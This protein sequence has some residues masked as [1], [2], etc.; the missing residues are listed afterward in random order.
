MKQLATSR[1]WGEYLNKHKTQGYEAQRCGR[2]LQPTGTVTEICF[3]GYTGYIASRNVS[4]HI[5]AYSVQ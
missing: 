5:I 3:A 1:N 4:F 2:N